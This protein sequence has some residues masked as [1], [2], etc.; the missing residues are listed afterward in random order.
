M[1]QQQVVWR[2]LQPNNHSCN[3][4]L[5]G[6][7]RAAQYQQMPQQQYQQYQQYQPQQVARRQ[8]TALKRRENR[9]KPLVASAG[10]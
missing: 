2:A 5:L 10:S 7:L 8:P 9:V 6:R 3:K 1:P 4:G